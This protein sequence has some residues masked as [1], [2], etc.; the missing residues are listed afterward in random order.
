MNSVKMLA[1]YGSVNYLKIA[2]NVG[3]K[4]TDR[5]EPKSPQKPIK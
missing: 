5:T 2:T 3:E 4:I 1:P